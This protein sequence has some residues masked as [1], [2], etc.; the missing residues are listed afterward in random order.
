MEQMIRLLQDH[1]IE[2]FVQDGTVI[3]KEWFMMNGVPGFEWIDITEW[4]VADANEWLGY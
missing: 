1:Q 3:A 2:V 4:T